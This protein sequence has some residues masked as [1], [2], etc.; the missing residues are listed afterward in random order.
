MRRREFFTLLGGAAASGISFPLVA[1]AQAPAM[2]V[3]GFLGIRTPAELAHL[4]DAFHQGLRET[5]YSEGRNVEI[6]YRWA[7]N[8]IDRLPMLAS[9]PTAGWR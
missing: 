8:H 7:E 5:G 6:Q 4:V 9:S 2:P 1:G 3:I